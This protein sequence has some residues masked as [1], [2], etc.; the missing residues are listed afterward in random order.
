MTN[1]KFIKVFSAIFLLV[2]IGMV[3][4]G[5]VFR[6]SSKKFYATAEQTTATI[7]TIHEYVSADTDR[8]IQHDVH[9]SY[10]TQEGIHYSNV[11][12][13]WYQSGMKEGQTLAV[14]Y[15]PNNPRDVRTQEGS[16]VSYIVI[17]IMGV[18]FALIGALFMFAINAE[19]GNLHKDGI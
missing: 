4:G 1:E 15:N 3:I 8:D 14:Y 10:D 5:F 13:G 18:V 12:L 2:G 17:M 11:D 16:M 9:I 7:D 19:N 6:N